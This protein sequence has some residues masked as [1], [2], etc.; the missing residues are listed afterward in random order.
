MRVAAAHRLGCKAH[1]PHACVCGKAV[2]ARGLHGL[3]CR[4]NGPR[5]QRHSRLNDILWWA[6][7]TAQVPAAKEPTGLSRDDG[8]RPDGVKLLPWAKGK[9]LAVPDTYADSHLAD[10]ATTA[11]AAANKAASNK[12]AKYRRLASSHIFV[13]VA[14]ETAGTWSQEAVQ[15]VQEMSRDQLNS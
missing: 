10:R 15:L 4:R 2:G 8:K 13:P 1:E 14:I 5:H 6:F 9:P 11:G 7:K 12:E 3:A